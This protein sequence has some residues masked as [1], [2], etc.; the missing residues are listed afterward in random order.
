VRNTLNDH[1][2]GQKQTACGGEQCALPALPP[3][4]RFPGFSPGFGAHS[5][6]GNGL[7]D[8]LGGDA[9]RVEFDRHLGLQDVEAEIV[10]TFLGSELAA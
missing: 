7:F 4:E 8:S 3:T 6:F 9:A 5:G 1:G 2:G 10:N